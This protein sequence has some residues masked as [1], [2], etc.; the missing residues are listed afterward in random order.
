MALPPGESGVMRAIEGAEEEEEEE[1]DKNSAFNNLGPQ[2]LSSLQSET[3]KLYVT[4]H[5][6]GRGGESTSNY[7]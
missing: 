5:K 4:P 3:Y 7:N 1:E 2:L 6:Y